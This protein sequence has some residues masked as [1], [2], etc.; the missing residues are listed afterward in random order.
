MRHPPNLPRYL[1][2][3]ASGYVTGLSSGTAVYDYMTEI[4]HKNIGAWIDAAAQQVG[5]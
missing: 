4:G 5:R 2:D 3:P 1:A